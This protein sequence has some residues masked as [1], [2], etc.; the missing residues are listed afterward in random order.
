MKLFAAYL[1]LYSTCLGR[2]LKGLRI[3]PWTLLLPW[4]LLLAFEAATPLARGLGF[5]GGFAM[6][7]L[8]DALFSCYLYF[9][10]EVVAESKVRLAELT[11]SFGAY[12]FAVMSVFF[13][14]WV[15]DLILGMV[16]AQSS[17]RWVVELALWLFA[18]VLLNATPEVIYQRG[19]RGGLETFSR[20]IKFVQDNWLEWFIPNGVGLALLYLLLTQVVLRLPFWGYL[21]TGLAGSAAFHVLM[22]FRG[23]LFRELDGLSH[24]QRMFKYR[25]AKTGQ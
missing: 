13:V 15:A 8:L 9:T 14:V 16:L 3:S 6:A 20:S 24:R 19:T 25:M 2:T 23:H 22:V 12:F 10:G 18:A 5:L 17:G 7:L 21:V 11:K 4:G 1:H